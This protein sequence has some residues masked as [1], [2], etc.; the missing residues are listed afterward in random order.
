MAL[1]HHPASRGRRDDT[2]DG[3]A[4]QA[5][6]WRYWSK[7]GSDLGEVEESLVEIR[8]SVGGTWFWEILGHVRRY[9]WVVP[10]NGETC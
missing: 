8:N 9:A 5:M 7:V 6:R 2:D 1:H 3:A 4:R 10:P